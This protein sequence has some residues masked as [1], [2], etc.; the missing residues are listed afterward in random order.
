MVHHSR[1]HNTTYIVAL[2]RNLRWPALANC[3]LL[4]VLVGT[5]KVTTQP[6]PTQQITLL[7]FGVYM[8][9]KIFSVVLFKR[10]GRW[11]DTHE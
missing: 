8:R 10:S 1:M 9:P 6:N 4:C 7:P 3:Q 11:V 2:A 5:G